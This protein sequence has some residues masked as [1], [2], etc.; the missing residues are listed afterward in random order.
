M[1]KFLVKIRTRNPPCKYN[2][3]MK[4]NGGQRYRFYFLLNISLSSKMCFVLSKITAEVEY[5]LG[6][7][8]W[9]GRVLGFDILN[10]YSWLYTF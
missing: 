4:V 10:V 2:G 3:A 9:F 7:S 1:N 5:G 6:L 8:W